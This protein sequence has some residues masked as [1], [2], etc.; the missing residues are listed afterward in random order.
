MVKRPRAHLCDW[1]EQA[2]RPRLVVARQMRLAGLFYPSIVATLNLVTGCLLVASVLLSSRLAATVRDVTNGA[3]KV[4]HAGS[5]VVWLGVSLT[6]ACCA[7][8]VSTA[9]GEHWKASINIAVKHR[10]IC[11]LTS[12]VDLSTVEEPDVT[13]AVR[14][15]V[16]TIE[17]N[18]RTPGDA[19]CGMLAYIT[20]Y[21]PVVAFVAA[22]TALGSPI[23]ATALFA[24]FAFFRYGHR[25]TG[26][27]LYMRLQK[28]LG[29][30]R[31]E[32]DYYTAA[33]L[34]EGAQS[35]IHLLG[36]TDWIV[37]RYKDAA[38]RAQKPIWAERRR[39]MVKRFYAYA[40]LGVGLITIGLVC[41]FDSLK[42][43]GASFGRYA[44]GIQAAIAVVLAGVAY[45]EADLSTQYGMAAA[46]AVD[47]LQA[48][49]SQMF[50][51]H[52]LV[53]D[54]SEAAPLTPR[55]VLDG[56]SY[57]YRS[58]SQPV[59]TGVTFELRPGVVTALVGHNGAGK[60]TLVKLL[61]GLYTPTAGRILADGVDIAKMSPRAWRNQIAVIFQDFTRFD[62]T[63]A[64]NIS[65]S[66]SAQGSTD[67]A[68]ILSAIDRAGLREAVGA[69][70][71]G[72]DTLLSDLPGGVSLSGG[73]WQRLAYARA[74]FAVDHGANTVILDEPT[75]AL[76]ARAEAQFFEEMTTLLSG[77]TTLL[78]SH[79][80]STVRRAD[81]IVVMNHGRVIEE[82]SHAQ[83]LS[84]G[85]SYARMFR[86]QQSRFT[87]T[88]GGDI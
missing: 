15:A 34:D 21:V 20:R 74:I 80:F 37:S 57:T 3:S 54:H 88:V 71:N 85:G 50:D 48:R 62:L 8:A 51:R 68:E 79:R 36:L 38:W 35:D 25:G 86:L 61:C 82:G 4:H 6:A 69:L 29:P 26:L 9:V 75:S 63:V 65:L 23:A 43:S 28:P 64:E 47:R 52:S 70:P 40:V 13:D 81:H 22:I 12:D 31:R 66:Y 55:V 56:V 27:R 17:T 1:F 2:W 73:Q 18:F 24:A 33:A 76:D 19:A 7:T 45:P 46:E 53:G 60:T 78:I 32:R 67:I 16:E 83:L 77:K 49:V 11:L 72:V 5:L 10:L 44:F 84:L 30:V 87:S 42:T 14:A 58:S 59:F 39:Y 41:L